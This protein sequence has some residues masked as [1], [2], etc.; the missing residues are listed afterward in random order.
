MKQD[1]PLLQVA[2]DLT[3]SLPTDAR[4][5]RLLQAVRNLVP[6]AVAVLFRLDQGAL[7]PLAVDGLPENLMSHR[8]HNPW[9][10][11]SGSFCGR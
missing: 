11:S 1:D 7:V 3:Q 5:S 2:L 6:C 9:I 8:F 4:Y 10:P